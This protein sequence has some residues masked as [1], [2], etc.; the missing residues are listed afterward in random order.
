MHVESFIRCALIRQSYF[1]Q[2]NL[3]LVL[4]SWQLAQNQHYDRLFVTLLLRMYCILS[5]V[6]SRLGLVW[7][8]F[9]EWLESM[10]ALKSRAFSLTLT[11]NYTL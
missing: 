11:A 8:A 1:Y 7:H 6:E 10:P 5:R 2:A 3:V 9:G 4:L